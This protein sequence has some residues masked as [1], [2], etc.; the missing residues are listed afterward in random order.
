MMNT[1]FVKFGATAALA[2]GLFVQAVLPASAGEVQNRL[3]MQQHRIHAGVHAGQI[4][5][6][7]ARHDEHRLAHIRRER[8]RDLRRNGG[9][10]TPH[11][12]HRINRQLNH[13]SKTI[14][15]QRR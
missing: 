14:Y 4:S 13:N 1:P 9:T 10:L 8:N 12:Y 15:D 5:H 7:Q 6:R 2:V 3:E 11:E